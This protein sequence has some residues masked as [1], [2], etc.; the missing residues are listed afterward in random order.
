MPIDLLKV[1]P[2]KIGPGRI[3]RMHIWLRH[4][5]IVPFALSGKVVAFV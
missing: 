4:K 2:H 3:Y 5:S 1:P